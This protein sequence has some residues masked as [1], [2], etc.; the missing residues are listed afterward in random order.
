MFKKILALMLVLATFV[1]MCIGLVSCSD[2]EYDADEEYTAV[3]EDLKDKYK[4]VDASSLK[5]GAI[6]LGDEKEGYTYAHIKG[7]RDAAETLGL[8][9]DQIIWKYNIPEGDR[10]VTEAKALV[11]AGCN[12]ILSNSYGHQDYMAQVAKENPNVTFVAVT[13]DFSAISGIDNL[14]NAFT[15]VYESRYVSGVVAGMKILE[16]ID[17]DKLTDK[18]YKDGAVKIGYVGAF[19]FAE[20]ISGYTAF[21]LGVKS[22]LEPENVK[23]TMDVQYTTS[24]FDFDKEKA[25]AEALIN[26]GCVI[27]GQHADSAGA[28]TAVQAAWEKGT[29]VY[30][31]GY[32]VD[33]LEVAPDTALTSAT[34][35]WVV[36]YTDMFA[37]K[38]KGNPKDAYD[39]SK[40]YKEGAVSITKLGEACADGTAEKVAE[41]VGKLKDGS[42]KVFDTSKFTVDGEKLATFK[43]DTTYMNWDTMT[44]IYVGSEHEVIKTENGITFFD[45]STVRSAPYFSVIID[46]INELN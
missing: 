13:G 41:A 32:N 25:T 26:A 7:I 8:S 11:D 42:L 43:F 23:V 39:W 19:D 4:D 3:L 46:G 31:A 9:A 22:V 1:T 16:L 10:V 35:N 18:N 17:D 44:P 27:I 33:M 14:T 24:W 36:F 21:Y 28:P 12:L 40:G 6:L 45:E 30:S 2:D 15:S 37:A 38:A 29:V 5:I 34:N 20:V